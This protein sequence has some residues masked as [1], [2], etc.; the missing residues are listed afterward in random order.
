METQN[1]NKDEKTAKYKLTSETTQW[2]GETLYRIQALKDFK[3]VSKGEKGG[4]ILKKENLSQ[5]GDA[6]VSGDARVFGKLKLSIGFFFGMQYK[7]EKIKK[8]K[9]DNGNYILWKEQI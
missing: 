3:G 6:W 1:T 4:F 2:F 7:N 9:T 5:E 8:I